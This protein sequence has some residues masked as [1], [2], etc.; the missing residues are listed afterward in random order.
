MGII[1]LLCVLLLSHFAQTD[2]SNQCKGLRFANDGYIEFVP[3]DMRPFANQ[4][5]VCSW[6]RD[7]GTNSYPVIFNYGPGNIV[8]FQS[9][10]YYNCMNSQCYLQV[11]LELHSA[12]SKGTWFHTCLTWSTASRSMNYYANGKLLGSKQTDNSTLTSGW[13]AVLG[14]HGS[15]LSSY[16]RYA[17]AGEMLSLNVYSKELSVDEVKTLSDA[18]M[19]SIKDD[20]NE[21]VR[22]IKWEDLLKKSRTG[23]VTEFDAAGQCSSSDSEV[24]TRLRQAEDNLKEKEKL[25]FNKTQELSKKEEQLNSKQQELEEKMIQLSDTQ[26]ELEEVSKNLSMRNEELNIAW[27]QLDHCNKT[28]GWDIIVLEAF[29]NN[30]ISS[31]VHEQLCSNWKRLAGNIINYHAYLK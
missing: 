17:F 4:M 2:V 28:S 1:R 20:E 31:E 30:T 8:R 18:G 25:L 9:N 23:N 29:V 16:G 3:A 26:R 10:G 24:L 14:N 6:I 15:V 19:C 22:V 12:V 7:L 13:K 11:G 27:N 5:S 21:D